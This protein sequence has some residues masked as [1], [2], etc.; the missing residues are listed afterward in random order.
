MAGNVLDIQRLDALPIDAQLLTR[1][2]PA[3]A[4]ALPVRWAG[5]R[6]WRS[7]LASSQACPTAGLLEAGQIER[8]IDPRSV[9][10]VCRPECVHQKPPA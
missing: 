4:S 7:S 5:R 9:C 1:I 3:P 2:G 10:V 6:G 8:L